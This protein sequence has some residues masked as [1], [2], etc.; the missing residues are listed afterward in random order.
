MDFYIFH[1][2]HLTEAND[3]NA[4]AYQVKILYHRFFIPT[5]FH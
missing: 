2:G 5:L 4:L 1:T 3:F